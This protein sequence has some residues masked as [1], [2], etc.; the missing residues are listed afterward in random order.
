M[1]LRSYQASLINKR[2]GEAEF[3]A[4]SINHLHGVALKRGVS[5]FVCLSLL[6]V[7]SW[8][9]KYLP[10]GLPDLLTPQINPMW[11]K[12]KKWGERADW[13]ARLPA[14]KREMKTN[15]LM[16]V[17]ERCDQMRVCWWWRLRPGQWQIAECLPQSRR[18]ATGNI[19][20][21]F[22]TGRPARGWHFWF[23]V[24]RTTHACDRHRWLCVRPFF[25]CPGYESF[26][27]SPRPL[28]AASWGC[29]SHSKPV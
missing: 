12:T 11:K 7:F 19:T 5:L 1:S 27:H 6:R 4:R 26:C 28:D 9:G 29:N 25:F 18:P 8:T 13:T 23:S 22:W 20:G 14:V 15:G 2:Y 24:H 3:K 10:G 21:L 17:Q 16:I